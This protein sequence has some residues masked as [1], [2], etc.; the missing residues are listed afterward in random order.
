M[1]GGYKERAPCNHSA[2]GDG[3]E[4][5][6]EEGDKEEGFRLPNREPNK[7]ELQRV[8]GIHGDVG[9]TQRLAHCTERG[10]PIR[11][12]YYIYSLARM[13]EIDY[14]RTYIYFFLYFFLYLFISLLYTLIASPELFG[15]DLELVVIKMNTLVPPIVPK[16][17]QYLQGRKCIFIFSINGNPSLNIYLFIYLLYFL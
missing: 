15:V 14:D 8:V 13:Q 11:Y 3:N 9:R 12:S 4:D 10:H 7:E 17:I 5:P 6:H 16:T 2:I 1:F